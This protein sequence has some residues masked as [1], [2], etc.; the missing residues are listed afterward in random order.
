MIDHLRDILESMKRTKKSAE[1][2][3]QGQWWDWIDAL[4][5]KRINTSITGNVKLGALAASAAERQATVEPGEAN[6]SLSRKAKA[7]QGDPTMKRLQNKYWQELAKCGRAQQQAQA[8]GSRT[9][10][11]G[12]VVAVRGPEKSMPCPGAQTALAALNA[13]LTRT[14]GDTGNRSGGGGGGGW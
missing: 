8:Q 2:K 12:S 11:D 3:P 14:Y 13:Y 6:A 7:M 5:R 10:S 1:E 4:G 9:L